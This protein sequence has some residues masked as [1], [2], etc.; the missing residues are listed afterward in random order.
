MATKFV[1]NSLQQELNLHS[2]S[3]GNQI[4]RDLHHFDRPRAPAGPMT[5]N[6]A[7]YSF[8]NRLAPPTPAGN[9]TLHQM[10]WQVVDLVSNAF[11]LQF[12]RFG[13]NQ[14]QKQR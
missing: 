7:L 14:T 9:D 3:A 8:P 11:E 5:I 1:L 13:V 12:G 4:T 10:H 6:T 2:V